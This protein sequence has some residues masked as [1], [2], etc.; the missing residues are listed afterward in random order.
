[1][2]SN[3]NKAVYK[4][5]PIKV[6]K[7]GRIEVVNP[8]PDMKEIHLDGDTEIYDPKIVRW[9]KVLWKK[10]ENRIKP[11]RYTCTIEF[12]YWESHGWESTEYD[13]DTIISKIYPN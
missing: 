13:A 9:G 7:N 6:C 10:P 11:G 2:R 4:R 5:V 1:M 3:Y 12:E 8:D